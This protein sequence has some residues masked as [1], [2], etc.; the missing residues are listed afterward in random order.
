MNLFND[1]QDLILKLN[2]S[3]E[4]LK[5]YG[6]GYAQAER[7]YKIVLRQEALKL[8]DEKMKIT[9]YELID[10]INNLKEK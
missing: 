10:E 5:K 7:Y 6:N 4:V 1:I 2:T 8:R 9:M 3:I